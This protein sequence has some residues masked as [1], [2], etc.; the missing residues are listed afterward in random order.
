MSKYLR[1][2]CYIC[3]GHIDQQSEHSWHCVTC[4]MTFYE[5]PRP[6]AEVALFNEKGEVLLAKRAQEPWKG[7]FD[8]P[9][10]FVDV[11]E[12]PEDAALRELREEL[13]IARESI[14]DLRFVS[15][16]PTEYPWGMEVYS[17]ITTTFVAK[18]DSNIDITPNDDVNDYLF[19]K[20]D[21]V[22]TS[23]VSIPVYP[24]LVVQ[25]EKVIHAV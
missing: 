8:L 20:P 22:S 23:M 10:G 21:A 11:G 13:G 2:F 24:E 9:G 1:N 4:N 19:I 5:S 6:C 12:T 25:A 17:T 3:G 16:W 7:K 14:S 18:L 15:A